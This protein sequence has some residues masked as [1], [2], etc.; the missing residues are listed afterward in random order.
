MLEESEMWQMY[1]RMN[2]NNPSDGAPGKEDDKRSSGRDESKDEKTE[3]N[4]MVDF[5]DPDIHKSFLYDE[6]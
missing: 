5:R 6:R 3:K 1:Y 2:D 4:K